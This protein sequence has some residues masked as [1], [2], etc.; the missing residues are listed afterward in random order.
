MQY[1]RRAFSLF[2]GRGLETVAP[3]HLKIMCFTQNVGNDD[4]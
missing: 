3:P 1:N 4:L 2:K